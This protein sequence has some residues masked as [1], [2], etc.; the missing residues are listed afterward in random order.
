LMELDYGLW[1]FFTP[2]MHNAAFLKFYAAPL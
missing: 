1:S 2:V